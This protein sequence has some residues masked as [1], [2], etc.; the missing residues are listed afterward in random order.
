MRYFYS[1]VALVGIAHVLLFVVLYYGRIKNV[2]PIFSSD[3]L[4]FALPAVLALDGYLYF[5]WFHVPSQ[6]GVAA[7]V[8]MALI[9]SVFGTI[10]SA[11]WVVDSN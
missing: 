7:R 3:F 5:A 4:V 11:C 6:Y 1:K 9:L 10:V 8:T 2:S